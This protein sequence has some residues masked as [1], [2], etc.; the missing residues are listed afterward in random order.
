MLNKFFNNHK[1]NASLLV[2]SDLSSDKMEPNS[3]NYQAYKCFV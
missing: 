2:S 3:L 1:I